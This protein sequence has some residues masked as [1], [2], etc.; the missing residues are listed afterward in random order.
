MRA[1]RETTNG[2]AP[3]A[4]Q[5]SRYAPAGAPC[6][7]GQPGGRGFTMVELLVVL[8]IIGTLL[9]I[10]LPR[11][12]QAVNAARV[13]ECQFQ[14]KIINTAAQAFLSRNQRWPA[15][16]EE[17]VQGSAPGTVLGAPLTSMPE[18]Q[19]GV[20]YL[21]EPV[22]QD[23][24]TG[25]PTAGNPQVGVTLNVADHFENGEWINAL[26]HKGSDLTAF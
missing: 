17:M 21:L 9:V 12:F 2:P 14:I 13:R 19:F 16:V 7:L 18:C 23:G 5:A 8:V 6:R 4:E 10:A 11:Y 15:S 3:P 26:R 1:K 22:L 20:P 25:Q 24:S